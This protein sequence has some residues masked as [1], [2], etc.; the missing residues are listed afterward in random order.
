MAPPQQFCPSC[1]EPGNRFAPQNDLFIGVLS[2][3]SIDGIDVGLVDFSTPRPDLVA[4]RMHPI[5]HELRK[6]LMVVCAGRDEDTSRDDVDELAELDVLVGNLFAEAVTALREQVG[7]QPAEIR[8]IGSHGQTVRHR[9]M[10]HTSGHNTPFTLQIADPN[11]IAERTGI[12]TVA[13]FRRRDMA[14]GGQGAPL[15]PAFHHAVFQ[16]TQTNRVVVNI[17]GIANITILPAGSHGEIAGFDTGP[18]N[19]LLDAWAGVHL[20][21][22]MDSY[23]DW[24]LQGRSHAVLLEKL[25]NDH[26][27][28][29]PPPKT[30]GREHFNLD[31][32]RACVTGIHPMPSPADIQR[33]LSDLTVT[34]LR[35]AIG[36]YAPACQEVFVCGGGARNPLL[37]NGLKAQLPHCLVDT[38]ARCGLDPDWVE[39]MTFAW[40]AKRRLDGLPGNAPSVTG[41]RHLAVL[42]AIYPGSETGNFFAASEFTYALP[43]NP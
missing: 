17:G 29:L 10:G 2:G 42:G 36:E 8:A 13:D 4:S 7:L 21:V 26:Y 27:F 11:I 1:P 20:D 28:S 35:D 16:D 18:G 31:W 23:G 43:P 24:A 30:S 5:P 15:V 40:L 32:L 6:R 41:A 38:T 39:A 19:I 22:P 25:R 14:A 9:P 34:T 12:T 37:L 33:T 3:T